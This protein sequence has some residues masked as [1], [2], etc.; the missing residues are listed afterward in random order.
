MLLVNSTNSGNNAQI[1]EH[2]FMH[3]LSFRLCYWVLYFILVNRYKANWMFSFSG[4]SSKRKLFDVLYLFFADSS[5]SDVNKGLLLLNSTLT[6]RKIIVHETV[7][8]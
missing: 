5:N 4:V 8:P 6:Y 3:F 2:I 7:R 1:D